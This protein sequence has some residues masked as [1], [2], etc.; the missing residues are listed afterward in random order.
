MKWSRVVGEWWPK[1]IGEWGARRLK[2]TGISY[3]KDLLV[4]TTGLLPKLSAC[5]IFPVPADFR[6]ELLFPPPQTYSMQPV[7]AIPNITPHI[8][9]L[10]HDSTWTTS[11]QSCLDHF[12]STYLCK[13]DI[14]MI[15][16]LVAIQLC[17]KAVVPRQPLTLK[18]R[19]WCQ[20]NTLGDFRGG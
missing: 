4:P 17:N 20:W 14:I 9:H 10:G 13:S 6:D 16:P 18:T 8:C 12:R 15:L 7:Y 3:T 5:I 11:Q 2:E 1:G 19:W